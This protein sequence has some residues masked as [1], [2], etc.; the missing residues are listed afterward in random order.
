MRSAVLLPEAPRRAAA[1]SRPSVRLGGLDRL[2]GLALLLMLLHHFTAWLA[3][4]PRDVLP[5]FEGLALTD[6]AAPAFAITA[7]AGLAIYVER[8]VG[9]GV[10]RSELRGQVLRRYGVLVPSG[11]LLTLVVLSNPFYFGVLD[12][13]GWGALGAF[14]VLRLIPSVPLR[15]ACAATMLLASRPAAVLVEE[16]VGVDYV[17]N[18]FTGKFP[19]LEYAGF[20]VVGALLAPHLR[21]WGRREAVLLALASVLVAAAATLVVGPPDRYPG[22]LAFVIPGLAATA[23]MYALMLCWTPRAAVN[24][25]LVVSGTRSLGIY[26][27]HYALFMALR[28]AGLQETLPGV[29][30]LLI[31]LALTGLVMVA[32]L[33][34]PPLPFSLRKGSAARPPEVCLKEADGVVPDLVSVGGG[35][36]AAGQHDQSVIDVRSA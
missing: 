21:R 2:R 12:A 10:A 18:A 20:A 19:I 29:P 23:V 34:L 27:S 33:K 4:R 35:V 17:V 15:W 6:F 13:L 11:M 32:A 26:I 7:G 8:S 25:A 5:G 31:A 28:A 30:A 3:N 24:R 36:G 1:E 16:H 22:G 9:R 14:L